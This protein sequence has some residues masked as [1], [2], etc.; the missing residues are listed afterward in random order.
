MSVPVANRVSRE[1]A[2]PALAGKCPAAAAA[3]SGAGCG[4][5]PSSVAAITVALAPLAVITTASEREGLG[6]K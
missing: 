5:T 1:V 4:R 6:A 3:P 2:A